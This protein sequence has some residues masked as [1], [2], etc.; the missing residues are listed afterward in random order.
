[1]AKAG[2][3]KSFGGRL[4]ES[5]TKENFLQKYKEFMNWF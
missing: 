3:K 4:E 2:R 5:V 1:M